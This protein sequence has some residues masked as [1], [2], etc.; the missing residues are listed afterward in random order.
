MKK[1]DFIV[2][3]VCSLVLAPFFL[4]PSLY[5]AYRTIN[6]D[7][8]YLVTF[9]KFA[10][11]ATFGE[12]VGLRIRTGRYQYP[13][14][15]LVPRALVWGFLGITIKMAFVI[16]GEGAP[17][18]LQTMGIHFPYDHPGD[19]LRT[20]AFTWLKLLAAFSVGVT[21]NLFFAP[22]FMTFHRITDMH[23]QR[24]GGTLR[25]FFS[26]IRFGPAFQKMDWDSMW[27][28]IFK[29]TIPF[30]WIPAQTINF[31]LPEEWRI[32]VAA[33]YSIILGILLS[34]ASLMAEKRV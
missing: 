31:L 32:L 20:S 24:T 4:F 12:S 26:P 14:F 9:F 29:K 27:N 21:L 15:G 25:G 33:L 19:V 2:L 17:L 1:Q 18:M 8:P 11:L 30:F 23:I 16:F 10:L 22:V 13:G 5:Q 7:F 28:F 34:V 6:A 3:I